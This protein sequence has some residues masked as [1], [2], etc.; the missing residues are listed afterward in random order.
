[1]SLRTFLFCDICN[2]QGIRTIDTPVGHNDNEHWGRRTTDG[3]AWFEGDAQFA[4]STLGW[5]ETEDGRHLCPSC[6]R[7]HPEFRPARDEPRM[8]AR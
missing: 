7:R 2:P 3:R 8:Q 4:V 6:T 5:M 1:M